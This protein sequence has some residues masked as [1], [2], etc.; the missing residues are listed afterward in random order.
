MLSSE[1]EYCLNEAFRNAREKRHEFLTV[2]HLLLALLDNPTAVEVLQAC[3]ADTERLRRDVDAFIE[4]TTPV[5]GE[6]DERG[7]RIAVFEPVHGSAPKYAGQ[8]RLNPTATILSGAL[9]LRHL[10]ELDAAK[11]VEAA[12]ARVIALGRDV[13]YDLK[14]PADAQIDVE[15]RRATA[16]HHSA[17]HLLHAALRRVLAILGGRYKGGDFALLAPRLRE[18]GSRV[19]AIGEARDRLQAV[20]GA[21]VPVDACDSMRAAVARARELAEPGDTVL[22]APACSSF[23]MFTDYAERG[24]AFKAEVR[25]QAG[26]R[27]RG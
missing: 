11:R 27:A 5:I 12:V 20:L 17:T 23:D 16:L 4:E 21:E 2:E 10:G 13:T 15:R 26:G 3:G 25:R 14:P 22:L 24:R 18:R 9:M 1:L 7:V 19:L 6:E 8:N